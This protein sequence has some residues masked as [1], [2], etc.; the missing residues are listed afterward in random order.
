MWHQ[1][2]F[3]V[4]RAR[5]LSGKGHL[6]LAV[7]ARLR[8]WRTTPQFNAQQIAE[9]VYKEYSATLPDGFADRKI[10]LRLSVPP[11]PVRPAFI[12]SEHVMDEKGNMT[13]TVL[14]TC[15]GG[16]AISHD[17][18]ETWKVVLVK[19]HANHL[20]IN[21]KAI[22]SSE[23]L[24]QLV[25]SENRASKILPLDLLVVDIHGKVLAKHPAHSH[26]WHGCRSVDLAG[27]AIM[28]AE[29]LSNNPV[30]GKRPVDCRVWRSHDRGRTWH[31]VFGQSGEEI[32]HFHFLQQRLGHPKEWWL[33]SGD[34]PRECHVWV[35][36]D[37]G[38]N[39]NDISVTRHDRIEVD[40]QFYA[41]DLYRMTDLFWMDDEV[42]WGTDDYMGISTPPGARVFRGEI[43]RKL[44]PELVG[45]GKWHIRSIVDI[46]DYLLFFSQRA[47]IPGASP[48]ERKPGVYLMAKNGQPDAHGL[49]HL[50]NLDSYPSRDRPGFT[51]SKASRAAA[52]GT[53]FTHRS[54]EDVFPAGHKILEWN[55]GLE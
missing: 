24:V 29:Y 43:R 53:F 34:L 16:F 19:G 35:S 13:D 4:Q 28:F 26:R 51:F 1:I 31:T 23:F 45:I 40:G 52:H 36:K 47:N 14:A 10:T 5:E 22:G 25:P 6:G 3:Y 37:D 39:W 8:S 15:N 54:S 18:G 55:V 2:K 7:R 49:V 44:K 11:L 42:I 48:E 46:G 20:F 17:L 38:D 9:R 12:F 27:G 30:D 21:I 33:T 50:F 32:R 41:R